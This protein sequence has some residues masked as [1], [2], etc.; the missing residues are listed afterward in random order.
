MWTGASEYARPAVQ[1][2]NARDPA[3]SLKVVARPLTWEFAENA[4][5]I[6]DIKPPFTMQ[7]LE[8]FPLNY[9]FRP[10]HLIYL[11]KIIS[12]SDYAV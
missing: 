9:F 1:I 4:Q 11:R 2:L 3:V 12:A 6:E 7:N 5:W 10:K 8:L